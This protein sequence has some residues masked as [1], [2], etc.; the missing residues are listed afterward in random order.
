[1]TR[2]LLTILWLA[3]AA[4]AI[5]NLAVFVNNRRA[6]QSPA[7]G[8]ATTWQRWQAFSADER[9]ALVIRY[10]SIAPRADAATIL[11]RAREFARLDAERQGCVR[12]LQRTLDEILAQQPAGRRHDLLRSPPRAQ[13]FFV[14]Q[15]LKQ[16]DPER[17]AELAAC[18]RSQG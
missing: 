12:N 4:L 1:M 9:R 3:V 16:H 10:Q 14:Y 6:A 15:V 17:L 5:A 11:R 2:W 8:P 13:A 18:L 7:R